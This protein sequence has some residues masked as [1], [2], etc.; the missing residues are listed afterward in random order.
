MGA[1]CARSLWWGALFASLALAPAV[2]AQDGAP[3]G[4]G[5][6]G[7]E[8]GGLLADSTVGFIDPAHPANVVRLRYDPAWRGNRPTRA[9][10]FF[11][12][13]GPDGPG[14]PLPE[15]SVDSQDLS[16]YSEMLLTDELSMFVETPF[17]MLNPDVN[18]NHAGLGDMTVGFKYALVSTEATVVTFQLRG[19]LPTGDARKGL[20]TDHVSLEPGLLALQWLGEG[21]VLEGEVRYWKALDGTRDFEGD[22]VRYGLGIHWAA[23]DEEEWGIAPVIEAVGWTFLGGQQFEVFPSG[24]QAILG[25]SGDTVVNVM[26]GVRI[27]L[28]AG[29]TMYAG[30]GRAVTGDVL[31]KELARVEMRMDY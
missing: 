9:E 8:S 29:A 5:V 25:A 26:A 2:C 22:L 30:Y 7:E 17:R 24:S 14:L 31:F 19:Y 18:A 12:R 1:G 28:G 23:L 21:L 11:A 3:V 20:G 16:M 13:T 10:Y 4:D 27:D 15:P 6:W